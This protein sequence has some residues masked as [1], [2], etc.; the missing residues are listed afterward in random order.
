MTTIA[1]AS[2]T[3]YYDFRNAISQHRLLGLWRMMKG[4]QWQYVAATLA[5]AFSAIG[6]TATFLLLRYFVDNVMGGPN[7]STAV[8]VRQ[9][10]R[11]AVGNGLKSQ[12]P[13]R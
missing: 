13:S 1:P 12:S 9:L 7:I 3:T 5:L 4:Y 6:K 8:L 11:I 2:Q 10:V